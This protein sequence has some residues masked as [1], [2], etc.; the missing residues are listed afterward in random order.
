MKVSGTVFCDGYE[1]QTELLDPETKSNLIIISFV[2]LCCLVLRCAVQERH[3]RELKIEAEAEAKKKEEQ[4]H[5]RQLKIEAEAQA[6]SLHI[7]LPKGF[8]IV[9]QQRG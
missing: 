8:H 7:G 9:P 6:M 1:F 5:Q 4:M 3:Q 2:G